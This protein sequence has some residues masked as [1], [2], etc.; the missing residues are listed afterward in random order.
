MIVVTITVLSILTHLSHQGLRYIYI[1]AA[2]TV[3]SSE[4]IKLYDRASIRQHRAT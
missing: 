2:A 3:A 1:T 4:L